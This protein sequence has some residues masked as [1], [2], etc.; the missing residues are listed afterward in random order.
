MRLSSRDEHPWGEADAVLPAGEGL[1]R[2]EGSEGVI[3]REIIDRPGESRGLLS[4]VGESREDENP[5]NGGEPLSDLLDDLD[6][7]IVQVGA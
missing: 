7:L 3:H 6:A 2:R 1:G 5:R 4:S